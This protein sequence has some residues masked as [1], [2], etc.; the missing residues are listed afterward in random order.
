MP[1]HMIISLNREFGSGG[2]EV[3][4]KLAAE[5]GVKLY[6]S[7]IIELASKQSGIRREYFEKVDEKPTDSFLYALA[8][9]TLSMNGS[10]NPYDHALSS[11]KLFNIQAEVIRNLAKEES[12]VVMGRCAEYILREEKNCISI[13]LCADIEKRVARIMEKYSLSEKEALKKILST[14]KKR[15]SYYGYYTGKDWRTCASYD[16][17]IDTGV[18]GTDNAVRLIMEYLKIRK[19][20]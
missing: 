3:G 5:L 10:L 13:Y 15:D 2:K 7:E 14:D 4:T 18:I 17:S 8:M 1:D 12:F 19:L 9:N 11:D 16:L 6:D 20:I